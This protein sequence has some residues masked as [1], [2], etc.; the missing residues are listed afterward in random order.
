MLEAF[1]EDEFYLSRRAIEQAIANSGQFNVIH[2]R[3]GHKIDFI[4]LGASGQTPPEIA[5]RIQIE[6][7]P[8][9]PAY[10]AAPDDIVIRSC[11]TTSRA[12]RTSISEILLAS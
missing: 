5:R 6:L 7:A 3:S 4:V 9:C 8:D 2:S 1:P 12:A 10:V 11:V